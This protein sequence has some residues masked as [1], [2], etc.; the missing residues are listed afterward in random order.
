MATSF[1]HMYIGTDAKRRT[2]VENKCMEESTSPLTDADA[3]DD[4][5][6]FTPTLMLQQTGLVLLGVA[7]FVGF[8]VVVC[9]AAAVRLCTA[10]GIRVHATWSIS[11]NITR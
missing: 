4:N 8:V 7:V 9:K 1:T 11:S 10:T 3:D 6:V 2:T 5:A